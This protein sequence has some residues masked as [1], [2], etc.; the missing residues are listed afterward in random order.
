MTNLYVG[1]LPFQIT[2][3][4]LQQAFARFGDVASAKIIMDRETG[5][6]RG[7]GFVTMPNRDQAE[8]AIKG[9]D[10]AAL[11]GRNVRVNE[12]RERTEGG[13]GGGFRNDRGPRSDR[14]GTGYPMRRGRSFG[15]G[16]GGDRGGYP[17]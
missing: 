11:K 6:S 1:N 16:G 4:E 10:G 12:A 9:M 8:A 3:E 5:R 17:G 15:H 13:G 7:F 2:E 14:G